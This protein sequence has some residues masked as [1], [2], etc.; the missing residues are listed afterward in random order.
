[1]VRRCA[2]NFFGSW[3][4]LF[5]RTLSLTTPEITCAIRGRGGEGDYTYCTCPFKEVVNFGLCLHR[6]QFSAIFY[7][8]ELPSVRTPRHACATR[9]SNGDGDCKHA[10]MSKRRS[11]PVT[12]ALGEFRKKCRSCQWGMGERWQTS[13]LERVLLQGKKV[14]VCVQLYEETCPE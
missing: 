3:P 9:G 6:L 8:L 5:Y 14:S 13:R 7:F 11:V 12:K 10:I 2:R 1:M 4:F